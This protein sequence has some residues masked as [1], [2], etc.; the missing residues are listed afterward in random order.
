MKLE[1][2][3]GSLLFDYLMAVMLILRFVVIVC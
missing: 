1:V 3:V 2:G